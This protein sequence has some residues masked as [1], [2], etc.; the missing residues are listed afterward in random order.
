MCA[1]DGVGGRPQGKD[2]RNT[3]RH[4]LEVDSVSQ[5]PKQTVEQIGS[6][7]LVVGILAD[8]SPSDLAMAVEAFRTIPGT[9]RVVVL[10]NQADRKAEA[11]AAEASEPP[12]SV[13]VLP[14]SLQ[15]S[16][17]LATP[18]ENASAGYASIFAV[19]DKLGARGCCVIASNLEDASPKWV[20]Q[21]A[22]PLLDLGSDMV[23]PSYTGR[24]FEG[25][26]NHC[27]I[28]P[29]TRCLYGKRLQNPMGP[30]LGISRRLVQEILASEQ[31][32]KPVTNGMYLL[33]SLAPAASSG[34][35][36]MHQAYLGARVYPPVDWTNVSSI[37]ADILGPIFV[38]MEKNAARWQRTRNSTSVEILNRRP[39]APQST[40]SVEVGRLVNSFQLG[41][42]DLLEIWGLVLPPATLLE[43]KKL[44]RLNA[45]QFRMPDD[46]WV[47][48]IYDFAL[49]HRLQTI[50]RDHLLK[51]LTPLYLGWVASYAREVETADSAAVSQRLE[52][53]ALAY[54]A[55]K[56][57]LISRW[58][59]PDRFNP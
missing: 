42:R 40:R 4:S 18:V 32:G 56:P 2:D 30:D 58:R 13:S 51:S 53:L 44:S 24:K 47:K 21:L 7:D 29:L 31:N 1:N 23:A 15:S 54:E 38:V 19:G 26:L 14:W 35:F 11:P 9:P 52:R 55:E 50:N 25:L 45:D 33:A 43:L 39:T 48:I 46:L 16:A 41:V 3:E 22:E 34:D 12:S 57:Y 49:G 5:A 17:A 59:W 37:L 27:I 8:L 10:R 36:Q 6:A 28:S 20:T